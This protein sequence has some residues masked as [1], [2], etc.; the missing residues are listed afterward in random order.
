MTVRKVQFETMDEVNRFLDVTE[1]FPFAVDL[2]RG[3]RTVNG[4]SI[5][6]VASIG[7]GR[8]MDLWTFVHMCR[9]LR[10]RLHPV[11]IFV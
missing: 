1:H 11:L 4:K 3:Y 5:L 8:E 7:L 10:R 2:K 9:S 6:G